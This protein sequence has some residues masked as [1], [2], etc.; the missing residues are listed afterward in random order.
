MKF[1]YKEEH[2]FKKCCPEGEKIG[3]KYLDW[4]LVI[5]EK[6]PKLRVSCFSLSTMPFH[7][8]V[9]QWVNCTRDTMK[10]SFYTS[11]TMTQM[12]A[13]LS[14]RVNGWGGGFSYLSFPS[15]L[16]PHF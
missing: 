7:P 8:P 6:A 12:V 16:L 11:P 15:F 9:P 14:R 5:V 1:V 4:I 2:P 3:K 10:T 13:P